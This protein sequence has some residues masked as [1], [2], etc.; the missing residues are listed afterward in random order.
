[1]IMKVKIKITDGKTWNDEVPLEFEIEEARILHRKLGE[2][3]NNHNSD[4]SD[5][6]KQL[7]RWKNEEELAEK[8]RPYYT[9]D[10]E[11]TYPWPASEPCL[12]DGEKPGTVSWLSCSCPKC[13]PRM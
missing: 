12:H 2:F 4:D 13:S 11:K 3:F 1:M 5:F 8:L 10:L 6:E 9:G 7:L